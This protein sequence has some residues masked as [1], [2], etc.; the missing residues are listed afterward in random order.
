MLSKSLLEW[1]ARASARLDSGKELAPAVAEETSDPLDSQAWAPPGPD[2]FEAL[3]RTRV[4][5]Q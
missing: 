3:W 1:P 4:E 5:R 2:T